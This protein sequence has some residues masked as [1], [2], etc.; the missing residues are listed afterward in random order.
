MHN[1]I[2]KQ[3][4]C[5]CTDK[6]QS[7]A[8]KLDRFTKADPTIGIFTTKTSDYLAI[9]AM[10]LAVVGIGMVVNE[11]REREARYQISQRV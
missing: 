11:M 9:I 8:R 1:C 6:C 4:G 2:A 3:F 7:N 5:S 10:F